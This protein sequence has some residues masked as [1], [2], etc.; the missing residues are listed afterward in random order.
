MSL[1]ILQIVTNKLLHEKIMAETTIEHL[2]IDSKLDPEEKINQIMSNLT[3]LKDATLKI[4]FWEGFISNNIIIPE[5]GNN[6]KEKK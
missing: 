3:N 1:K 2:L 5:E 6:N 4:E